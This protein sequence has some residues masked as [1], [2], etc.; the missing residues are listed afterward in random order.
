MNSH[1]AS[2]CTL[3]LT[4]LAIGAGPLAAQAAPAGP[5]STGWTVPQQIAAAVL[6][7]PETLREGAAVFGWKDG[8]LVQLRAGTNAMR[9]LAEDPARKNFHVACY[10]DALEPFMAA[11][12][13]L[14]ARGLNP[15]AVDS[16]RRAQLE[17]QQWRMPAGPTL[18]YELFGPEGAYDPV[19]QTLTG[20]QAVHVVYIPY[21]TAATT[22][23]ALDGQ[24]G[25][26]PW[27]MDPG[28]PWAH[29]MLTP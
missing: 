3:L 9:C 27:L 5:P 18:L 29:I 17:A 16:A 4:C 2:P 12:R 11:G 19:T 1:A 24:K 20:A 6:P 28:E 13:T 21:A 23:L 25:Y 14:R 7:L 10:H 26:R 22:G 15:A 8:A